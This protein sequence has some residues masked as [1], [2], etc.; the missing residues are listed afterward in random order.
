M[1][2]QK[3]KNCILIDEGAFGKETGGETVNDAEI[4]KKLAQHDEQALLGLQHRYEA[5][6]YHIA[7]SLLREEEAAT[8]CVSDVWLAIWSMKVFPDDLKAYLAKVTRNAA[9]QYLRKNSAKKRSATLVLLDE[10]AECI[11]D[12][13]KE[14]EFEAQMLRELLNAFVQC[15]ASSLA[16]IPLIRTYGSAITAIFIEEHC[17]IAL[18]M[19]FGHMILKRIPRRLL[20]HVRQ[21]RICLAL[22]GKYSIRRRKMSIST[23]IC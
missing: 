16:N 8:E 11:P 5:Y 6:C 12:P 17:I 20:L 18:M 23:M 13:L 1:E 4:I 21:W 10:L 22:T 3:E 2:K 7:F 9:L 15:G 14:G 19:R